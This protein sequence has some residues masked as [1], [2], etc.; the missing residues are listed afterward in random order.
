MEPIREG[1]RA[2]KP[3][4]VAYEPGRDPAGTRLRHSLRFPASLSG[5]WTPLLRKKRQI[6]LVQSDRCLD[7]PLRRL[8]AQPGVK[9]RP[10]PA[11]NGGKKP[12]R[13]K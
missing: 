4:A 12:G 10:A 11:R 1:G 9:P 3:V 13:R 7:R 8:A 2:E 5:V 6:G